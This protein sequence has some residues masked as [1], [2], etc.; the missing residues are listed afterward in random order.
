MTEGQSESDMQQVSQGSS[1]SPHHSVNYNTQNASCPECP[2]HVVAGGEA[3]VSY[4]RFC[5][6][7]GF[8][9]GPSGSSDL[10]LFY[11]LRDSAGE[12]VQR[13]RSSGCPTQGTHP[14]TWLFD[15]TSGYLCSV[16]EVC[17]EVSSILVLSSQAPSCVCA[18]TLVSFL[19]QHPWVRLDLFL[20][21]RASTP[22]GLLASLWPRL[23]LSPV[24]GCVWAYLL[25]SFV[26]DA[27]PSALQ[28]PLLPGRAAADWENAVLMS[29]FAGVGP[30]FLD[31][32]PWREREQGGGWPHPPHPSATPPPSRG[33]RPPPSPMRPI[34]VV[35]HIR[36]PSKARLLTS[37]QRIV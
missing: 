22:L 35:R 26:S 9:V 5:R 18:Q 10:L 6:A 13:G 14:E 21:Q 27:P 16:L 11:E 29:A 15:L 4:S 30:A 25:G 12:L 19:E 8:P 1:P 2:C 36:M 3:A 28:R 20:S 24:S 34:N 31:L 32:Q 17:E 23:S 37:N 7:F 33:R